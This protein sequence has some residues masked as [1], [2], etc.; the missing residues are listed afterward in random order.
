MNS[1]TKIDTARVKTPEPGQVPNLSHI[2]PLYHPIHSPDERK[3]RADIEALIEKESK[4][5][6]YRPAEYVSK[7]HQVIG[8]AMIYELAKEAVDARRKSSYYKAALFEAVDG[9]QTESGN[10]N[11]P[12]Q[13]PEKVLTVTVLENIVKAALLEIGEGESLIARSERMDG[14]FAFTVAIRD[15]IYTIR[16]FD[17]MMKSE[18]PVRAVADLAHIIMKGKARPSAE[19]ET[20]KR[21]DTLPPARESALEMGIAQEDL[22]RRML[23]YEGLMLSGTNPCYAFLYMGAGIE[24]SM[25]VPVSKQGDELLDAIDSRIIDMHNLSNKPYVASFLE[26][27]FE[28][29]ATK[30]YIGE[31]PQESRM[32]AKILDHLKT[33]SVGNRIQMTQSDKNEYEDNGIEV[34]ELHIELLP[35]DIQKA[36]ANLEGIE[37][38]KQVV[39]SKSEMGRIM[40]AL[41]SFKTSVLCQDEKICGEAKDNIEKAVLLLVT[42]SEDIPRGLADMERFKG[43]ATV[44]ALYFIENEL[45]RYEMD[46]TILVVE[47]N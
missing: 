31:I 27:Y 14:F 29:K 39:V 4:R 47:E 12:P 22:K 36:Y 45:T 2:L 34:H 33:S 10:R 42:Q 23:R 40:A 8:S 46:N 13:T 28:K 15:G 41:D 11:S 16:I 9:I 37:A 35:E 17:D 3:A 44:K 25:M 1:H 38:P 21:R 26:A 30:P 5:T 24:S 19:S 7:S 6:S 43:S 20:R 32:A 18:D